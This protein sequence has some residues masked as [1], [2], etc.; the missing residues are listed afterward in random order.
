MNTTVA[1]SQG[2]VGLAHSIE[3]LD[4]LMEKAKQ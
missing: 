3:E 4:R 1:N 2:V